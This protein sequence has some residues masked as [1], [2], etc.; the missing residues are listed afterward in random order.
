MAEKEEKQYK[1]ARCGYDGEAYLY[2][3]KYENRCPICSYDGKNYKKSDIIKMIKRYSKE[4]SIDLKNL[5]DWIDK[6]I[7]E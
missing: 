1:C 6:N 4:S 2:R 7:M 3:G 5:I